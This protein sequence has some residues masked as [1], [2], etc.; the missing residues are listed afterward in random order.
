[1]DSEDILETTLKKRRLLVRSRLANKMNITHLVIRLAA[2]GS[3]IL[4]EGFARYD[5]AA[6]AMA[7]ARA[8]RKH[9]AIW[10]GA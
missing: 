5:S 1:M 6:E 8:M 10:N 3:E 9:E 2:D 7:C 4:A